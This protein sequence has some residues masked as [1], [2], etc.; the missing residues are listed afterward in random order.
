MAQV[1]DVTKEEEVKA[2]FAKANEK[3]GNLDILINLPG[4]SI[5]AKISEMTVEQYNLT[6]S[7]N[8]MGP[9]LCSKHFIPYVDPEKGGLIINMSSLAGIRANPN[10]P[11]CC[12]SKA[13]LNMLSDGMALQ[14][15]ENN[16]RVTTLNPGA[17]DT[18][19]W[20]QRKVAREKFM[21]ADDVAD[22][23]LFVLK[24]N[25]YIVFHEINFESFLN[26]K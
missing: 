17:T 8:V 11:L 9:F 5:P 12:T 13:A 2:F 16:I 19:F 3:Y 26:F 15:K 10:S 23:V 14:L 4:L 6:M 24:S 7:V 20:G 22:V 25:D 18:D 1:V 21:K